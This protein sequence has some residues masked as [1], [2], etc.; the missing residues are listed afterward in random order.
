M[1]EVDQPPVRGQGSPPPRQKSASPPSWWAILVFLIAIAVGFFVGRWSA[2]T[3]STK[4]GRASVK[5]ISGEVRFL[6][7]IPTPDVPNPKGP[8]GFCVKPDNAP[9]LCAESRL[10]VE[11]DLPADGDR[12]TAYYV[13][14]PIERAKDFRTDGSAWVAVFP[15]SR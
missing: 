9:Q 6:T 1:I 11:A 5:A 10:S 8:Y 3:D 13:Y 15:A 12:V 14:V 2:T 7:P 4:T